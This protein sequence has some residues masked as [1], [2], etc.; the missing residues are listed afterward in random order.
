MPAENSLV[1][2]GLP[3]QGGMG[4]IPGLGTKIPHAVAM[5]KKK[6]EIIMVP[7]CVCDVLSLCVHTHTEESNLGLLHCRQIVY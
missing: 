5:S 2:Q 4:L 3:P 1:A 6:K 7:V